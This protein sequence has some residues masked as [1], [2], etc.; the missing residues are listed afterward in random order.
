MPP[1]RFI[2]VAERSGLILPL[3]E[4]LLHRTVEVAS[5]WQNQAK[6]AINVSPVQINHSDL[7]SILRAA[8]VEHGVS[9]ARLEIEITETALLE[10]TN[11]ALHAL[12]QIRSMGVTV[13]LD[14]F[15]TGYSSLAMLRS[16]PFDKIKIDRSFVTDLSRRDGH[17]IVRSIAQL[18]HNLGTRVLCEGV[19]TEA[20]AETL[21]ALGCH[22]MQGYLL[23][24]PMPGTEASDW[25]A[26]GRLAA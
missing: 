9:P 16:F 22:E 2:T 17:A 26:S 6:V 21:D 4:H 12:R 14:D 20:E 19:E 15:G 10:H 11:R 8:M 24:R 1:D 23:S 18:G 25:Q 3:G 13:A 7:P 5:N